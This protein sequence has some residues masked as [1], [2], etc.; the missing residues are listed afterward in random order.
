[1]VKRKA[2]SAIT[3]ERSELL[4]LRRIAGKIER[5]VFERYRNDWGKIMQELMQVIFETEKERGG[6]VQQLEISFKRDQPE[7]TSLEGDK[8]DKD[9]ETGLVMSS[10]SN[11][12]HSTGINILFERRGG[13]ERDEE[14]INSVR[15]L[16]ARID[17]PGMTVYVFNPIGEKSLRVY[18]SENQN[19]LGFELV[20]EDGLE[21]ISGVLYLPDGRERAIVNI[22]APRYKGSDVKR[23]LDSFDQQLRAYRRLWT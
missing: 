14:G 11:L 1:M 16:V 21:R 15:E 12:Y 7:I 18:Y 8:D 6:K 23:L 22:D 5:E 13:S 17:G 20:E 9:K 4:K 19:L 3:P 2:S 10:F